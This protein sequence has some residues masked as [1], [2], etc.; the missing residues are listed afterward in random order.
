MFLPLKGIRILD[1]T[2]LLP[3][4]YATLILAD[5][6]AEVIKVEDTSGGDYI[7]WSPPFI[8]NTSINFA[9]LNR[10]KKSI[11]INLKDEKGREI[12]MK[13][14]KKSDVVVEGFRPGVMEKLGLSYKELKSVKED[15]I[16][17]SISGYGQNGPYSERA[18]HDLNYISLAGLLSPQ[19]MQKKTPFLFPVQIADVGGGTLFSTIGILA[20]IIQKIKE[21]RGCHIDI[22][23]ADG[24]L[25]F[26]I[27]NVARYL[28]DGSKEGN[29]TLTGSVLCYNTYE[30]G[31]GKFISLAALEPKFW[32]NFINAI[33]EN[34]L[35]DSAFEP[36]REG[37]K[38][39]ERLKSIFKQRS[40]DEWEKFF[41]EKDVCFSVVNDIDEVV[42]N[43]QFKERGL[44]FEIDHPD[45]GMI[46]QMRIPLRISSEGEREDHT[47]PPYIGEHTIDI[48]KEIAGLS[49]DEINNLKSSGVV[50]VHE[51]E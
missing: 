1:L 14:V 6:G 35:S 48:L 18:G 3:G 11:S 22:S 8:K 30:T 39:Y 5:L 46:P 25:A 43:E 28:A 36:A 50:K 24:A 42:K 13:L 51:K 37:E 17:C 10:N 32:K 27:M 19:L 21:K 7:R 34:E 15:I 20:G 49:T 41:K 31:D 38:G 29:S 26:M 33:G 45:E 16:L 47:P 12:F 40:R 44:F 9:V 4:P 23:M 2:R